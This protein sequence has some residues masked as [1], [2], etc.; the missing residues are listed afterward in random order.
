M[1]DTSQYIRIRILITNPPKLDNK[2]PLTRRYTSISYYIVRRLRT[3][4]PSDETTWLPNK[5]MTKPC[6]VSDETST[7]LF[8]HF[9]C[10][11]LQCDPSTLKPQLGGRVRSPRVR[12]GVDLGG[13][14]RGRRGG[15]FPETTLD[16]LDSLQTRP[17]PTSTSEP[18]FHILSRDPTPS[19]PT[20]YWR[21]ATRR[22]GRF[23]YQGHAVLG[24][25]QNSP[26]WSLVQEGRPCKAS[27]LGQ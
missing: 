12:L 25:F 20:P 19:D 22:V 16:I 18:N 9:Q 26:G 4:R 21:V 17:D 6:E 15:V 5:E 14:G 3:G 11:T 10:L 2:P 1:Q 27:Y 7:N 13:R 24:A 23:S 8:P